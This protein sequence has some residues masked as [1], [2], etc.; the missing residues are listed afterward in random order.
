MVGI[1]FLYWVAGMG[2]EFY[3]PDFRLVVTVVLKISHSSLFITVPHKSTSAALASS[4]IL[5]FLRYYMGSNIDSFCDCD[6][7][8]RRC[9]YSISAGRVRSCQHA[10]LRL[11]V[12]PMVYCTR[13]QP[14]SWNLDKRKRMWSDSWRPGGIRYFSLSLRDK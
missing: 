11:A 9:C 1:N 6:Q 14:E 4:K 12:I 7:F 2:G 8:P 5:S 3:I 13:T 10:S